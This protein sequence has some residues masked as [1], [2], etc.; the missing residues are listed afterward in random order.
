M[1]K[2][3]QQEKDRSLRE[4][5][6]AAIDDADKEQV[7]TRRVEQETRSLNNNPR[8]DDAEMP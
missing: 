2:P 5:P 1:D 8:N 4:N 3:T 6:G 7:T